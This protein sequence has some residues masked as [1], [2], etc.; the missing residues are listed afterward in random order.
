MLYLII[1]VIPQ[2]ELVFIYSRY[3]PIT[4]KADKK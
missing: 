2:F 3:N 4:E 1:F